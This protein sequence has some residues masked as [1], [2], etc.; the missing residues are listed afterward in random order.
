MNLEDISDIIEMF[1]RDRGKNN[2]VHERKKAARDK[3]QLIER[4]YISKANGELQNKVW[5]PGRCIYKEYLSNCCNV[6]EKQQ[7]TEEL[8]DRSP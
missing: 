5:D 1:Q 8:M 3:I 2:L 6:T 7:F 4:K